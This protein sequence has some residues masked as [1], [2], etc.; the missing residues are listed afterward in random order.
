MKQGR[1]LDMLP[2]LLPCRGNSSS[3][4]STRPERERFFSQPT[5]VKPDHRTLHSVAHYSPCLVVTVTGT[6]SLSKWP[7]F[8]AASVLFCDWTANRSCSSRLTPHCFATFSADQQH[9]DGYP[10]GMN[11]HRS[12]LIHLWCPCGSR[13]RHR[14]GR[15]PLWSPATMSPPSSRPFSSAGCEE[16]EKR[17]KNDH[18][19]SFLGCWKLWMIAYPAHALHASCHHYSGFSSQDGLSTQTHGLQPGATHHLT[20]PGWD[21]VGDTSIDTG[22]ACWVLPMAL[23]ATT[24]SKQWNE[25]SHDTIY[26]SFMFHLLWGRVPWWPQ[27]PP[28]DWA[29]HASGHPWSPRNTG[30]AVAPW[31]EHRSKTLG[32]TEKNNAVNHSVSSRYITNFCYKVLEKQS[33]QLMFCII[34]IS[35]ENSY[36]HTIIY[37][38]FNLIAIIYNIMSLTPSG[39]IYPAHAHWL[40]LLTVFFKLA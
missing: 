6:I 5:D 2:M 36:A 13:G 32:T 33:S 16:P 25:Y 10:P 12:D 3:F 29:Q 23:N 21:R 1:R 35:N 17:F 15:Q 20:A 27:T 18:F 8:C 19:L 7:A 40:L 4:T 26:H 31:K 38:Y 34:N 24:G 39:K 28:L 30:L 37:N 22:L 14:S 11:M 9:S